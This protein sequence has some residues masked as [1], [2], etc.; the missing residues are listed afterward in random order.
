MGCALAV[1]SQ[2]GLHAGE[3]VARVLSM[4]LVRKIAIQSENRRQLQAVISGLERS[5]R[6]NHW[7]IHCTD[8]QS[9]CGAPWCSNRSLHDLSKLRPRASRVATG[10]LTGSRGKLP[11]NSTEFRGKCQ[12]YACDKE[13]IVEGRD[14]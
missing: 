9:L 2:H 1:G 11:Q 12:V 5:Q 7:R 10:K 4:I 14:E 3:T 8:L 6:V 13:E